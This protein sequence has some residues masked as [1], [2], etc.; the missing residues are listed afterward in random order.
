ME[1]INMSDR[2]I[3][4]AHCDTILECYEKKIDLC[5]TELVFNLTDAY[6]K[7][8]YIQVLASYI[9]P[10]HEKTKD[11][12]KAAN[13]LIDEFY[14]QKEK[15]QDKIYWITKGAEFK[16]IASS[17]KVGILL[18]IENSTAIDGRV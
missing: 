4:D 8:P 6:E 12:F 1:K 14:R 5:D 3:F 13:N 2:I 11:G 10:K 16:K 17:G 7:G 15:H 18:S 9:R